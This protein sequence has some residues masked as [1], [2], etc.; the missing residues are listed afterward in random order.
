MPGRQPQPQNDTQH[1]QHTPYNTCSRV[2]AIQSTECKVIQFPHAAGSAPIYS[3]GSSSIQLRTCVSLRFIYYKPPANTSQ[4][5]FHYSTSNTLAHTAMD[6]HYDTSGSSPSRPSNAATSIPSHSTE[7]PRFRPRA[8]ARC[9]NSKLKC[10]WLSE[11]G[12]APCERC[13]R[14]KAECL[15]PTLKPRGPRRGNPT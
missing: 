3:Y 11:P 15:L 2:T 13:A 1:A 14:I 6:E 12:E 7:A 9:S 5:H 4:I 8:C 10:S